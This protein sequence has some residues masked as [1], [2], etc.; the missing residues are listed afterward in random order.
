MADR[1]TGTEECDNALREHFAMIRQ[2]Y[3]DVG[4]FMVEFSQLH[5]AIRGVLASILKVKP[6]LFN[7]VTT[8]YSFAQLCHVTRK[9][10][11]V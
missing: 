9:V 3:L 11:L 10:A 7:A 5:L 8:P 1:E 2:G 4:E 6:A